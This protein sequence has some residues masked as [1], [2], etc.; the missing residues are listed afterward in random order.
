MFVRQIAA[1]LLV[2]A[3]AVFAQPVLDAANP[4]IVPTALILHDA[5]PIRLRLTRDLLFAGLKA[6]DRAE[7]EVMD[8]LRIDG[9]LVMAHGVRST[10]TITEVEPKTRMGHGGK[11]GVTLASI[12]LLN[13]GKLAIRAAKPAAPPL[14]FAFTR[15]ETFLED[16]VITVFSDGEVNLDPARFLVDMQFTSNPPGALVSM[17]GAPIGRTPFTTRLAPGS[18]KTVFSAEG[19]T[20]LTQNIAVGPGDSNTVHAA[21]TSK[22]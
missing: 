10:A 13:G 8:D 15:E 18:Y 1:P 12:P 11:F 4:T 21:F 22:P 16:T 7:F 14:L 2:S 17:Y 19:Y 6:G 3:F 5:T 20:D 9:M